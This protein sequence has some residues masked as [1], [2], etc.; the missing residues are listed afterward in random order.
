[1][2]VFVTGTDTNVGKTVVSTILALKLGYRYWKPLQTGL[3]SDAEFAGQHLGPHRIQKSVHTLKLA[4]SPH[5][6]AFEE[7]VDIKLAGI[8]DQCPAGNT[9]I[10][11]A[12]GV[13]VPINATDFMVDV[14]VGLGGPVVIVARSSLGTLNHTLLTV[15]ALR[16]R[17]LSSLSVVLVGE[18]HAENRKAVEKYG[19]IP[20]I[21]HVPFL[22]NLSSRSLQDAGI[23]IDLETLPWKHGMNFFEAF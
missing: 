10:E 12:G 20:V 22:K 1:M 15:E 13:L 19:N 14:M 17:G 7:S 4:A 21:G 16:V 9:V 6:A 5:Q 2:N 11:G 3:E 8:L 23:H 18:P